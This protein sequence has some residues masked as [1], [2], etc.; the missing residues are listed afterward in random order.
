MMRHAEGYVLREQVKKIQSSHTH[1]NDGKS[2]PNRV[3]QGMQ[4]KHL[5]SAEQ[6]THLYKS[7][8]VYVVHLL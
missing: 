5:T 3:R 4:S 6:Q 2:W 7:L 1:T 8:K